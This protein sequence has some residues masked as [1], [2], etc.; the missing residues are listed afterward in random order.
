MANRIPARFQ[1]SLVQQSAWHRAL[2]EGRIVRYVAQD[3]YVIMRE[4]PTKSLAVINLA[5]EH[6]RIATG[7]SLY[8][9]ANIVEPT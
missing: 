3:G 4:H 7:T 8:I 6:E 5:A 2:I 1:F 9:S